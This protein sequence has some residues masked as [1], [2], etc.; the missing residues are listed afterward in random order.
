MS[1]SAPDMN[2]KNWSIEDIMQLLEV[3]ELDPTEIT[4]VSDRLIDKAVTD[5]NT[6]V[7][8]FLKQARDKLLEHISKTEELGSFGQQATPALINWW[9]NQYLTQDNPQADKATTRQ[10]HVQTFDNSHYQMKRDIGI[11]N[12]RCWRGTRFHQSQSQKHCRAYDCN[13]QPI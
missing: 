9:Q 3:D 4:A 13:R 8:T 10:N 1:S 12:I 6:A 2:I 5:E 11:P 7:V